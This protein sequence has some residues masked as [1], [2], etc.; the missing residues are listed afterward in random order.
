M[1]YIWLLLLTFQHTVIS[2]YTFIIHVSLF[3]VLLCPFLFTFRFRILCNVVY[4]FHYFDT[5]TIYWFCNLFST[6]IFDVTLF[7]MF[8]FCVVPIFFL[9]LFLFII[10]PYI[11]QLFPVLNRLYKYRRE[12]QKE[13]RLGETLA[14]SGKPRQHLP[15]CPRFK[16]VSISFLF[17]QNFNP[18]SWNKPKY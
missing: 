16:L 15:C 3:F 7:S 4:F 11:C 6:Y 10:Y 5:A 1:L 18:K 17:H 8:V 14:L 2:S 12:Q 9:I 13:A